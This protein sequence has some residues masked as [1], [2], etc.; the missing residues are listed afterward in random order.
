MKPKKP[1]KEAP[2]HVEEAGIVHRAILVTHDGKIE[3]IT[4][5]QW[6]KDL[7]DRVVKKWAKNR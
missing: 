6:D 5:P 3:V 4:P 2:S 1:S 7:R